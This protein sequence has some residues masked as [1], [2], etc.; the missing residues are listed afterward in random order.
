MFIP[1]FVLL[2]YILPFPHQVGIYLIIT[3]HDQTKIKL[4]ISNVYLLMPKALSCHDH[5][6]GTTKTLYYVS[7]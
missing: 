5:D 7:I 1:H 3:R 2:L 4:L 6:D